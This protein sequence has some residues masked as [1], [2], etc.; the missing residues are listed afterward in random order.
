MLTTITGGTLG[1]VSAATPRRKVRS[2]IAA[3]AHRLAGWAERRRQLRA[4]SEL[5]EHLLRDIGL[6]REDVWRARAQTFWMH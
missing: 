3:A 2:S 5:E 1:T 6:S 4:L